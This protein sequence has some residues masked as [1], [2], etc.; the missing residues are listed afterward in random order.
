MSDLEKLYTDSTSP[1]VEKARLQSEGAQ[2]V[3]ANSF[4]RESVFQANFT[5]R[6]RGDRTVELSNDPDTD[7]AGKFTGF[8][9]EYYEEELKDVSSDFTKY[10]RTNKY[11]E[12]HTEAPG[13][14]RSSK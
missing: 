5:T 11:L 4:D 10:N 9:K 13:I 8:A 7:L 14:I 1:N 6:T 3:A 12:S 2:S